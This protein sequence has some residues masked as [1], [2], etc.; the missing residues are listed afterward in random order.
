MKKLK[1]IY[2]MLAALVL[3]SACKT[4]E[5]YTTLLYNDAT[6]KSFTLGKL[7]RYISTEK[8]YVTGS[9]YPMQIDA[10]AR[11]IVNPDSLPIYTDVKHVVVS[12][13]TVN[14]GRVGI[15]N[16]TDDNFTFYAATDSIDFTTERIFRVWAS[17]GSGYSDYN[18]KVN[19][20]KEDG[21]VMKW[22]VVHDA[23]LP[24]VLP[25]PAALKEYLG[26]GSFK[27]Y[28]D[29]V[30]RHYCEEYGISKDNKLMSK[31]ID[32]SDDKWDAEPLDSKDAE[33]MPH[34]DVA[35]VSYP[36]QT[37]DSVDYV[38][39]VG[40][41]P[42]DFVSSVWR[43]VV[44]YSDK[45]ATGQ[46]TYIDR[47]E[48]TIGKLPMLENLNLIRYD[49]VTIAI[50]GDYKTLYETRDNGITWQETDRITLPSDFDDDKVVGVLAITDDENYIWLYCEMKDNTVKVWRGRLNKLGWKK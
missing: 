28:Q 49:G 26:K 6:I 34:E 11:T 3:L 8:E 20:H 4:D 47:S 40:T 30:G 36:M 13:A 15:K 45:H 21:D 44:D 9:N 16:T 10:M 5:S 48:E 39:L 25:Q 38:L 27:D 32:D 41:D 7:N 37:A 22:E 23:P 31:A 12:I 42:I 19:L 33:H 1:T 50:G 24:P 35:M 46:W 14:N 43:K 29:E 2:C 17:D 18:V